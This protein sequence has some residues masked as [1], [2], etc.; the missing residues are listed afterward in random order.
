MFGSRGPGDRR[1]HRVTRSR[2]ARCCCSAPTTAS[3]R[4]ARSASASSRPRSAWCCPRWAVELA[5]ERLSPRHFQQRD[6]RR[7]DVRPRRR[8]RRRLP[9]RGRRARRP[10]SRRP[11]RGATRWAELPRGGVP[12]PGA[13]MNRGDRL[14]AARRRHRRRPGPDLRRPRLSDSPSA[15]G[16]VGPLTAGIAASPV[17]IS[18]LRARHRLARPHGRGLLPAALAP[19]TAADG[20]GPRAPGPAC[21]VGDDVLTTSGIFGRIVR[22]GDDDLPISRSRP[23]P[24][25][26]VARGAIGAG[27]TA[28]RRQPRRPARRTE[29][30]LNRASPADDHARSRRSS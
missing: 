24:S 10:R 27:L 18:P 20:S 28:A 6:G 26:R 12:R 21:S 2:P 25:I 23:A 7:A 3:A 14:G 19:A 9:R 29:A 30:A 8:R 1:V 22:L 11:R 13:G 4:A 5:R 17:L 16:S 15:G